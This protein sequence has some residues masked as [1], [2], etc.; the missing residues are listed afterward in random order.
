MLTKPYQALID[1]QTASR[2]LYLAWDIQAAIQ[3]FIFSAGLLSACFI[4]IYEVAAGSQP[5]SSFVTLLTYWSTLSSPLYFFGGFYRH[6]QEV[7]LDTERLL[8]LLREKPTIVNRPDA[9]E[10]GTVDGAVVFENVCFSY[11]P[12]KPALSDISFRVPAGST[13]AFVGETGGGKTTCLR[14]LF[15]FYDVSSGAIKIDGHDI[16]D[17]K[18]DNLR[19]NIGVVPQVSPFRF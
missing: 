9:I 3:D 18:L 8:A 1:H 5:V 7:V 16:R 13:V 4:A 19:N 10:L 12:R 11:D 15:R 6:I 17:I 2:N 14:L